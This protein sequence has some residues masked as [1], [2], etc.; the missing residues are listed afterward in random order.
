MAIVMW[1]DSIIDRGVNLLHP[2]YKCKLHLV[3]VEYSDI[4][5]T[6]EPL[7]RGC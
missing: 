1:W 2:T 7:K 6:Y 3:A 4:H 5:H